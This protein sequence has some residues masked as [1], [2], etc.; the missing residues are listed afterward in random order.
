MK[1]AARVN[2]RVEEAIWSEGYL[3]VFI[4]ERCL[5]LLCHRCHHPRSPAE[6]RV[7]GEWEM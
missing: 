7:S 2:W 4:D 5:G 6:S 1:G 3:I